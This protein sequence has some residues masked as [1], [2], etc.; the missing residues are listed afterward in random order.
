MT[1]SKDTDKNWFDNLNEWVEKT[2]LPSAEDVARNKAAWQSLEGTSKETAFMQENRSV[3]IKYWSYKDGVIGDGWEELSP[4][5]GE[6]YQK[7]CAKHNLKNPGDA[8]TITMRWKNG[9]WV[10]EENRARS[11]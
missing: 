9:Q 5:D 6:H 4:E 1:T 10:P 7:A 8:N 11:A 3:A 2:P